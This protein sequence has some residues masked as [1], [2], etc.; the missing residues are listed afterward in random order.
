MPRFAHGPQV[1]AMVLLVG[2]TSSAGPG[3]PLDEPDEMQTDDETT[4]ED[5]A[6]GNSGAEG[7]PVRCAETQTP[8]ALDAA[9]VTLGFSADDLLALTRTRDVSMRWDVRDSGPKIMP[10]A[11]TLSVV[12]EPSSDMAA[13]FVCDDPEYP[14]EHRPPPRLEVPIALTLQTEDRMLDER[15]ETV[16]VATEATRATI[17]TI[18]VEP[19][20]FMGSLGH[21]VA[22]F[23]D[24]GQ[25]NLLF[26]QLTFTADGLAGWILGP[27]S[28]HASDPCRET[29]YA[30]WPADAMCW[31]G[32]HE[33]QTDEEE[34]QTHL[35]RANQT[36]ELIWDGGE[37]TEATLEV[38]LADGPTCRLGEYV[39]H[40]VQI[41]IT[42]SDGRVDLTLPGS[43]HGGPGFGGEGSEL[44]PARGAFFHLEVSAAFALDADG[45]LEHLDY[46][47]AAVSAAI[48]S[49]YVS[50]DLGTSDVPVPLQG[51]IRAIAIDRTGFDT[52]LPAGELPGVGGLDNE[53]CFDSA[54]DRLLP[55]L[56][57][58]LTL[59]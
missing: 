21:A 54:T 53:R 4:P 11:D 23:Y 13:A 56:R 22:A 51:E 44:A 6:G 29:V 43:L 48:V 49:L 35:E 46:A 17:E 19:E 38:D 26:E 40:R 12:V 59:K 24:D 3:R 45:L 52:P 30:T 33:E 5:L 7:V 18:A 20:D 42:T 27:F 58:R 16:L 9:D 25:R 57:G 36:L 15:F 31:P 1:T 41:R 37:T 28:P 14:D 55:L 32:E 50:T 10:S 8:L 47:E 34:M 39:K 2:C